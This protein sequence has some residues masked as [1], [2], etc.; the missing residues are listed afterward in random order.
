MS[1]KIARIQCH[2]P[3]Q[4]YVNS[5][6]NDRGYDNSIFI[7]TTYNIECCGIGGGWGSILSGVGMGIGAWLARL[8]NCNI[9]GGY[10]MGGYPMGGYPMGGGYPVGGGYGGRQKD[11]VGGE[12][13]DT[14][15]CKGKD[16]EYL[17]KL[18]T[19]LNKLDE[20]DNPAEAAK[21]LYNDIASVIAKQK[22]DDH[23]D[24]DEA[25]YKDLKSDL[26]KKWKFTL[27][28]GK[29]ESAEPIKPSK[30]STD[31]GKKQVTAA[32]VN[33]GNTDK[34]KESA[35]PLQV[36][37]DNNGKTRVE[38]RFAIHD[39]KELLDNEIKGKLCGIALKADK[40]LNYYVVDCDTNDS[41]FK[42]RYKI[43]KIDENTYNVKCISLNHHCEE[44]KN[45]NLYAN[46]NGVNYTVVGDKLVSDGDDTVVSIRKKEGY[47]IPIKYVKGKVNEKEDYVKMDYSD[48][49]NEKIEIIKKELTND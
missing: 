41:K 25:N 19:R 46:K 29:A 14:E 8:I 4:H 32:Q 28:D 10:P 30:E 26:E 45:R 16:A 36:T 27:K 23:N 1:S 49:D 33:T 34:N 18:R 21:K 17:H 5:H 31:D 40:K 7:N 15:H 20:D 13:K 47:D 3:F 37:T 24:I 42:L 43:T 22:D 44:F 35:S 2:S 48:I 39:G 6:R 11:S 12:K 9:Y 38:I